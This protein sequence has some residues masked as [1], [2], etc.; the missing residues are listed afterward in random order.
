VAA[1]VGAT[2]VAVPA[3][4]AGAYGWDADEV[5]RVAVA[6]TRET[7][8]AGRAPGVVLVRF[9]LSSPAV[10]AAFERELASS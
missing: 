8:A 2:S 4:G 6:A 5:A 9:V 3:I 10:H 7:L 1:E